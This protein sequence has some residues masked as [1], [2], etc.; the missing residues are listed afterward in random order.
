MMVGLLLSIFGYRFSVCLRSLIAGRREKSVE[1]GVDHVGY[2]LEVLR[3]VA[4]LDL[5][6][7]DDQEL[8]RVVGYPLLVFLVE[9]GQVVDA[10][11]L[12]IVAAALLDLGDEV[13][14]GGPEVD[15]Q[16]GI[17]HERHHEV[18]EVGVVLEVPAAHQAHVVEVGGED[19]GVL[20]DG[21]VLHYDFLRVRY[22]HHVLEPLVQE[23]DLE[24][25]RPPRHVLI[26][27]GEVGVEVYRFI[28]G[29]PAVMRGQKPG[30]G[31]LA[32]AYISCY[33]YVHI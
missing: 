2:L 4:E 33:R 16:V 27:V 25:E 29:R 31:R 28:L 19:A 32:A 1:F 26:E 9:P 30:Q 10:Y 3:P 18:E 15:Q 14:D 8:P 20:V 21:A 24:V 12:L 17:A 11:G 23:I 22:L 5:V 13:G 7:V 6:G